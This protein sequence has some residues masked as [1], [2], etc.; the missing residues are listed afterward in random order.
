MQNML[1][2]AGKDKRAVP[3]P[4]CLNRKSLRASVELF[5]SLIEDITINDMPIVLGNCFQRI[6]PVYRAASSIMVNGK[7]QA[8]QTGSPPKAN[9]RFHL[10]HAG[11]VPHLPVRLFGYYQ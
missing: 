2:N 7:R 5:Q 4:V 3:I 11:P 8:A 6:G 9:C 10:S 1:G